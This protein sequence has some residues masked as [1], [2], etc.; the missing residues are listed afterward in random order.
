ML[1]GI[2]NVGQDESVVTLS[3][4]AKGYW[5]VMTSHGSSEALP[6]LI[7]IVADQIRSLPLGQAFKFPGDGR[8]YRHVKVDGKDYIVRPGTVILNGKQIPGYPL[9]EPRSGP[10]DAPETQSPLWG[11]WNDVKNLRKLGNDPD[12]N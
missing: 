4:G 6:G 3:L 9:P 5:Y 8:I 11:L 7:E 2:D 12:S 10:E 1:N